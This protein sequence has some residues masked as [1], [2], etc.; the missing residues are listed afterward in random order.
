MTLRSG[1]S[2]RPGNDPPFRAR[3]QPLRVGAVAGRWSLVAGLLSGAL[4][5][6]VAAQEGTIGGYPPDEA[7]EL[8]ERMYREGLLPSGEP[9]RAFV[10]E[11]KGL[12][13]PAQREAFI[14]S[15]YVMPHWPRPWGR[16]AGAVEQL[17]VAIHK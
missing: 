13:G 11:A 2:P 4:C 3:W 5:A 10:S 7:L 6:V 1:Q 8:G 12:D 17:V 9:M 16:D 14:D 15:G